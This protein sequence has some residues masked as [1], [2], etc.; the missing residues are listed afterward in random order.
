MFRGKR[1][2]D[3]GAGDGRIAI[4]VA[5]YARESVG[6]DPDAE[7]I[8]LARERARALGAANVGFEVAAAQ[9]LPFPEAR[10]DVLI[11]SWTL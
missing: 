7:A 4:G 3:V 6:V 11:L 1:V 8:A 10:F 2:L 5:P 9:T